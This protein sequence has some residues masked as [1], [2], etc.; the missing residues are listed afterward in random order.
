MER[1][2]RSRRTHGEEHEKHGLRYFFE[3]MILGFFGRLLYIV[4]LVWEAKRSILF[5]LALLCLLD[6]VLPV[7]S[8]KQRT[9]FRIGHDIVT[10][11]IYQH[12]GNTVFKQQMHLVDRVLAV[13]DQLRKPHAGCRYKFGQHVAA[14]FA[15]KAG[16]AG[17]QV[18][19]RCIQ[20]KR[21]N[22]CGVTS[23]KL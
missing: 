1:G 10:I 19:H 23:G 11:A 6:G 21:R 22:A 17:K 16:R 5:V 12:H 7:I 3:D 8:L 18:H 20:V 14:A 13:A 4:S 9:V 15:A 2:S